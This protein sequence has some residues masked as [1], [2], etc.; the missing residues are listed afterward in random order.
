MEIFK[1][2]FWLEQRL[3]GDISGN[4][5]GELDVGAPSSQSQSLLQPA[6]HALLPSETQAVGRAHASSLLCALWEGPG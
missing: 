3:C 1:P 5:V 6:S 4:E 2:S